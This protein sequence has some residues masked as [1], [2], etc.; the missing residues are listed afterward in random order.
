MP[1]FVSLRTLVSVNLSSITSS[2]RFRLQRLVSV[3]LIL[4]L[5]SSSA[6][7]APR[8]IVDVWK[9]T[10]TDLLFLIHRSELLALI[11]NGNR[12]VVRQEKQEERD[13]KIAR[14]E[15]YPDSASLDVSDKIHFSAAAFDSNGDQVIGAK[16]KWR[17]EE[18]TEHHPAKITRTGEFQAVT[19]GSFIVTAE[20]KGHSAQA[21]IT[22]R[23]G[24]PRDTKK[25]PLSKKS[26]SS[27]DLPNP[28][29]MEEPAPGADGRVAVNARRKRD[30]KTRRAHAPAPYMPS[31]MGW[32]NTNYWSADDAGH[33]R[34][35]PNGTTLNAG[36]GNGN[37]QI[38]A[39]VLSL[40]GR[41]INVSLNLV[42]N[43][44]VWNKAGSQIAWDNDLDWPATGWSLGFGRV[45]SM[46]TNGGC[47]IVEA[48]GTR[49]SYAGTISNYSWGQYF[50]GH[51]TDGTFIDYTCATNTNGVVTSANASLPTGTVV[52]YYA[53]SLGQGMAYPTRVTDAD[54]NYITMTYTASQGRMQTL[55]DT[56]G[57]VINFHYGP[58]NLL[59]AITA[60]GYGG[61]TR[62]VVRIHYKQITL[63]HGW[64]GL[65]PRVPTPFPWVIDAIYYPGTNTGYWFGDSD[66]YS[67]YGMIAKVVE[68]RGMSFSASSL[69][70][71]GTV[72]A[73]SA[74]QI[75]KKEV[76]NY[77]M[78]PNYSLTDAP[79]YTTCVETWTRDGVN[80]DSATT[81]Y[82]LNM[83][84]N[85]RTVTVT[86]PNGTQN[87][88][89]SYN[90][91]G[92]YN[93]GLVYLDETKNAAG[94]VIQSSSTS[95]EPGYNDTPRPYRV[96]S[97]NEKGQTSKQEFSYTGYYNQVTEQRDYD[98]GGNL[99]RSTRTSYENSWDYMNTR[100]IF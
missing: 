47:M 2:T 30:S 28:A 22:V 97:T 14:I 3:F 70:D 56:L 12:G 39:P 17:A 78:T 42:Y 84:G 53:Y 6:P 79:T 7:A 44:K 63:S 31:G 85:P 59:T 33:L 4:V 24:A 58:N 35:A 25:P 52:E 73:P 23:R 88:Q 87:V 36:A 5:A 92:Q 64:S 15:I 69:N 82:A 1:R 16:I 90:A 83:Q 93:D 77:P 76:Y 74:N 98:F 51:T 11:Q 89:Y 66:S 86:L 13:A 21:T 57:R 71:M 72:T 19:P 45:L 99:M 61:G 48:D 62:T 81:T 10:S 91:P 49:H 96:Q 100:H 67:S 50:S 18:S 80:T 68:A 65:T 37:F 40:A 34:G 29:E 60:P 26:V 8:L 38:N 32:D 9:E 55:T 75:T 20:A 54:G 41:G 94:T 43:S 95:W 46:G 27:R